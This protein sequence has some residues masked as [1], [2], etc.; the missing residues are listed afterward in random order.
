[1]KCIFLI[2][3]KHSAAVKSVRRCRKQKL[4]ERTKNNREWQ[5]RK[6]I[7]KCQIMT[8]FGL[9]RLASLSHV[10]MTMVMLRSALWSLV[11]AAQYFKME[12]KSRRNF[13]KRAY[14][15]SFESQ[16]FEKSISILQLYMWITRKYINNL[17]KTLSYILET[18]A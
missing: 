4:Y 13:N 9:W 6:V 8:A 16:H 3:S 5:M 10:S 7:W 2:L 1:M 15:S 14:W 17:A 12:Q 18:H 11:H